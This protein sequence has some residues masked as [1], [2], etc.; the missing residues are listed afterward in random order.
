MLT[1]SIQAQSSLFSPFE[2][3][4]NRVEDEYRAKTVVHY[5]YHTPIE[6]QSATITEVDLSAQTTPH[7]K[8]PAKHKDRVLILTPLKDAAKYVAHFMDLLGNLTYPHDLIDIAMLVSDSED[9]TV[10]TLALEADRLQQRLATKFRDIRIFKR[11]F[12]AIAT[13][14]EQN[15][16]M[17]RHAF[18]FQA[19][20]RK[21]L[22]KARNYL[23]SAA[24]RADHAW[25]LW[26]DADIEEMPNTVIEDLAAHDKDAIVPAIWFHRYEQDGFDVEGRYDYNSWVE[27]DK[28]RELGKTLD[29]DIVLAEGYPEY[30]TGRTHMCRTNDEKRW[31]DITDKERKQEMKLDAVGGVCILVKADVHRMGINFPAYAFENQA[32]TEGFGKMLNRAGLSLVGLPNYVVWHVDT[33][34]KPQ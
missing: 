25:V 4:R 5:N 22:G 17:D 1:S 24:L 27:S 10:A 8:D 30:E 21:M 9:E 6:V 32:E 3:D 26:L 13:S 29:R 28:G 31:A 23:L 18:A 33:E 15:D 19:P 34:E 12:G 11:D 2:S 14:G 7:A 16:V 20:R